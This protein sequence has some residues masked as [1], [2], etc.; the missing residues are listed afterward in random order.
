[1]RG[2][3]HVRCEVGENLEITSKSYLSPYIPQRILKVMKNNKFLENF[4]YVE[5]DSDT[6]LEKFSIVEKEF[7]RI[8][9]LFNMSEVKKA[10]LR[11]RKLGKHK[12]LGLYYPGLRCLC[13]DITSPSSFMHEFGHRA[14]R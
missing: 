3:S 12:A 2:N 1:M 13:V 8:R 14:T 5:L 11:I 4:S 7:L 9:K 6:D 10:E